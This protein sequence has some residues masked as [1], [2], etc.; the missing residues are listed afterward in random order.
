MSTLLGA[1]EAILSGNEEPLSSVFDYE[2]TGSP[3]DWRIE[4]TPKARRLARHLTGVTVTGDDNAVNV[5][6]TD[7]DG[8]ESH[9]MRL[10]KDTPSQ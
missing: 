5:I 2:V 8:G 9:V 4:L 7:L 1:I 3:S 6:R 10:L